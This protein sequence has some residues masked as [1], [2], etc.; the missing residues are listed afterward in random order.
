MKLNGTALP[1]FASPGSYLTLNRIWKPG[2]KIELSLPMRLHIDSMPDDETIQAA[3]YGPLVLAGR[4]DEVTRDMSYCP[5]GP[6]RGAQPKVPEIS[7]IL[8]KA[9]T[10]IEPDRNQSLAFK[11]VGQ[12]QANLLDSALQSSYERDAV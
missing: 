6:K 3:M 7:R 1:A 8:V 4:F 10:W 5:Y 9:I 11:S 2:D 12:S